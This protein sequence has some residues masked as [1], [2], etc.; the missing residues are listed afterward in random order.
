MPD[1]EQYK[2]DSNL[3]GDQHD[4]AVGVI[5]AKYPDAKVSP[6]ATPDVPGGDHALVV[7]LSDPPDE[8]T[9]QETARDIADILEDHRAYVSNVVVEGS[10]KDDPIANGDKRL[11]K[12]LADVDYYHR[13]KDTDELFSLPK[14]AEYRGFQLPARASRKG[15]RGRM[16][17]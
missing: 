14:S 2:L 3:W 11:N 12:L 1:Y 16:N 4:K 8:L 17:Y 13:E 15:G 6:R 10:N 7:A 9:R 5:R